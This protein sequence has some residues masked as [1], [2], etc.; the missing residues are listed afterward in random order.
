MWN[1]FLSLLSRV[2]GGELDDAFLVT[3]QGYCNAR[4]RM[5][6]IRYGERAYMH[7]DMFLEATDELIDFMN[8]MEFQM[9][10]ENFSGNTLKLQE[11]RRGAAKLLRDMLLLQEPQSFKLKKYG[12]PN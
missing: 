12:R 8:Y 11:L 7:K 3:V 1:K 9:E 4:K 5:G 6:R 2:W 10:K